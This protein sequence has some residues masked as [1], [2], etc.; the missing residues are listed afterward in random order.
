[1]SDTQAHR[2]Q[3]KR[4]Y[5]AF[6]VGVS[7]HISTFRVIE[8]TSDEDAIGQARHL[9]GHMIEVWDRGRMVGRCEP[10]LPNESP[11]TE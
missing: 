3:Q 2:S 5:R 8:A 7:G 11:A 1:M 6:L 9:E 10:D 4:P